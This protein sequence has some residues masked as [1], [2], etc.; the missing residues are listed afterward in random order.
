MPPYAYPIIILAPGLA[1]ILAAHYA[2]RRRQ[3]PMAGALEALMLSVAVW[4]L[5]V[6]AEMASH[7]LTVAM[8]WVKVEYLGIATVPVTF[9]IFALHYANRT[10]W[11]TQR[12]LA[13][14][15]VVPALTVVLVATNELH[16]LYYAAV[17][18]TDLGGLVTVT[19]SPGPAYWLHVTYSYALI[20]IAL[21]IIIHTVVRAGP[22]Q[23]AQGHVVLAA[24]LAPWVTNVC[25]LLRLGPLP[26]VD[27][28]PAAFTISG[29][30]LAWALFR[31]KLLDLAPVARDAVFEAISDGVVVV[32][33][34]ERI[35][36]F[37]A[38]A[39]RILDREVAAVLGWPVE[40]VLPC[41][42]QVR[43]YCDDEGVHRLKE[44]MGTAGNERTYELRLFLLQRHRRRPPSR[45]L[46][47][48]D[49]TPQEHAQEALRATEVSYHELFNAVDEAIYIQDREGRFLDTNYGAEA[50]FGYPRDFF[51]GKTLE[52]IAAPGKND[53]ADISQK[54]QCAF[55]GELQEFEFWG[56]RASGDLFPCDVHLYKGTYLNQDV[57]IALA[58][59]ITTRKQMEH[60]QRLAAAG[61]LAAGVAHEFNNLLAAMLLQ[62]EMAD[63]SDPQESREL[64]E[65]VLR[66]ARRGGATCADLM[67][68][69]RPREPRREPVA[70]ED[71]IERAL[72][73]SRRQCEN[74][75]VTVERDNRLPG[76]R[77][78]G[79]PGQLEQV[80][81]NLIINGV[82][83]M[84]GAGVP[85]G[86]RRLSIATA[87]IPEA[88]RS[89]VISVSDTGTGIAPEHL[90]RVF[91][92]FF[93]TKRAEPGV[94]PHGTGLGLSVS[95]G[96]V[97]AHGGQMDVRSEPH[98]GTTFVVRLPLLDE[99]AAA[100]ETPAPM[101]AAR[102]RPARILLAEDETDVRKAVATALTQL[103][104]TVTPARSTE[105][106]MGALREGD[107]DVVVTDLMMPGAG[108]V[109]I[110]RQA[111]ALA[112]PLPTVVITGKLDPQLRQEMADLGAGAVLQKPF[113]L[114]KLLD[115][116]AGL[117]PTSDA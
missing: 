21:G 41:W 18:L 10:D 87:P 16:L 111:R 1:A 102:A 81:L 19:P 58:T 42:P 20:L 71:I 44:N 59:D 68:F 76:A 43:A 57:V 98:Q 99:N 7:S 55:L 64:R 9:L 4:S 6:A 60:A 46:F 29:L 49:I 24:A 73:V 56:R 116:L 62:A 14:L 2:W 67:A 79:D 74:A 33:E 97:T 31:M 84:S 109:A 77:V 54:I 89:L 80:L 93:T 107:F 32:D 96:I 17:R 104:H 110:V 69:A 48:S 37:N 82:Q 61:Q 39:Q 47:I 22:R 100:A 91:E 105:E 63:P 25:Y 45:L 27:C 11:L 103:G 52:A 108:G 75:Q 34:Y 117:L 5:G 23:R 36:D 101:T 83:A 30:A 78:H 65:V 115:T 95:H 12:R 26:G 112:A 66:S 38:A 28:T 92:P 50:M 85:L 106:A 53:L 40:H 15:F 3:M 86:R 88:P 13:A 51:V 90:A 72:A 113:S 35:V 8:Q 70:V 94:E 114:T